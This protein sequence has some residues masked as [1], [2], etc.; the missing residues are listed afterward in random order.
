[1]IMNID[2]K[3]L[4]IYGV[5]MDIKNKYSHVIGSGIFYTRVLTGQIL[6]S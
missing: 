2:V 4:C 1:M 3:K 5:E 6:V